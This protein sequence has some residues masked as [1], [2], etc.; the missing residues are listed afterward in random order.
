[1]ST[2]TA[3]TRAVAEKR[4]HVGHGADEPRSLRRRREPPEGPR[5][6]GPADDELGPRHAGAHPGPDLAE[7][8]LGRHGVRTVSHPAGEDDDGAPLARRR[9]ADVRP[10][11][12][13]H[14]SLREDPGV[15]RRRR[16]EKTRP[17]GR[18]ALRARESRRLELPVE[19]SPERRIAPRVLP[20]GLRERVDVVDDERRVGE[21]RRDA[22]VEPGEEDD[23][24]VER[25]RVPRAP[26]P[27][28][29]RRARSEAASRAT[30]PSPGRTAARPSAAGRTRTSAAPGTTGTGAPAG[31][32]PTSVTRAPSAA[33]ASRC[34]SVRTRSP[35]CPVPGRRG[36]TRSALTR[37]VRAGTTPVAFRGGEGPHLEDAGHRDAG[38]SRRGELVQRAPAPPGSP[39][40]RTKKVL[41]P[42]RADDRFGLGLESLLRHLGLLVPAGM[43]RDH[44]RVRASPAR[45]FPPAPADSRAP[46]PTGRRRRR[47]RRR[48]PAARASRRARPRASVAASPASTPRGRPPPPGPPPR[49]RRSAPRRG[50]GRRTGGRRAPSG[51]AEA[52]SGC[53]RGAGRGGRARRGEA[54]PP[55]RAPGRAARGT[56]CRG[57][58][59]RTAPGAGRVR[60]RRKSRVRGSRRTAAP[61]RRGAAPR[62]TPS[63]LAAAR[64]P[65]EATRPPAPPRDADARKARRRD[66]PRT[67]AARSIPGDGKKREVV[68]QDGRP[69]E[70][71]RERCR[72]R[73]RRLL[74]RQE[75]LERRE[76][77]E[78]GERVARV[79]LRPTPPRA[80]RR[81]R[82]PPR[83]RPRAGR[84]SDARSGGGAARGGATRT[85]DRSRTATSAGPGTANGI[86][87]SFA[88]R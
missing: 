70:E 63:T 52:R 44:R 20:R 31:A 29:R 88:A 49:G 28:G 55:G 86:R 59:A 46:A 11:G 30:P 3:A 24:E 21:E 66:R 36:T 74:E 79:L 27:T 61:A 10:D 71:S 26:S 51:R 37:T 65:R 45:T 22:R 75:P 83:R 72:P 16:E 4:P 50:R 87:R 2:G 69:S 81:G 13:R 5:R 60:V 32:P 47:G 54:P 82:A 40:E 53:R 7:E 34:S 43:E 18:L 62:P 14:R 84:R 67:S 17:A 76:R 35:V 1:M 33:S 8:E 25:A 57:G 23:R 38:P 68:R 41:A 42:A 9:R 12:D 85:T 19:P 56:P 64:A 39:G 73:S 58:R 78:R 48:G 80:E 6:V 77:Q 15:E